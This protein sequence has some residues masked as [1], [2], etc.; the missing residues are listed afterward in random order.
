[1]HEVAVRYIN[2]LIFTKFPNV[3]FTPSLKGL[4]IIMKVKNEGNLN[5][6]AFSRECQNISTFLR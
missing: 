4:L 3:F 5:F 1:M 2:Y 6:N